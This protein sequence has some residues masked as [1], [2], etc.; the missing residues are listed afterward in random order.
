MNGWIIRIRIRIIT[1]ICIAPFKKDAFQKNINKQKYRNK[2]KKR[3][4][5]IVLF[6]G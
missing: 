3:T 1:Y 6:V 4:S 5:L 2:E